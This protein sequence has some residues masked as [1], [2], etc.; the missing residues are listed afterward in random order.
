MEL[1]NRLLEIVKFVSNDSTVADIGTD[2]GYIPV[3]LIKNNISKHVIAS[4]ISQ[5]S[6]DK[7]IEYV[8]HLKLNK[9][10]SPRLG[11]GLNVLKNNEVDT[12][13][14]AGMGG[15]LISKI[16]ENNKDISNTIEN[17]ILQPMVA[18][19]ELRQYLINNG[20]IIINEGLAKEGRRFYEIIYAK[21]GTG[22]ILEDINYEIGLP[23][24]KNNHPLLKEFIEYKKAEVEDVLSKLVGKETDHIKLRYE[25]LSKA[26]E[27]YR[28][29]ENE[30]KSK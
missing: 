18:S 15:I 30:L 7:T 3:Y 16:L 14:I 10:I 29:V 8:N 21:R 27:A 4:D 6:L 20:Y 25:E 13:I 1:S 28:E 9:R 26:L 17:F 19:K 23:L 22:R 11:D 12:V 24:I 5:G 2:H